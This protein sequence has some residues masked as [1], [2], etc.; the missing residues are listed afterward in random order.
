MY[1][2]RLVQFCEVVGYKLR[3][4]IRD[5]FLWHDMV[6]VNLTYKGFDYISS[7][8][9]LLEGYNPDE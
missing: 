4:A 7:V 9:H 8:E 6:T 1:A 2:E 3:S 5:D